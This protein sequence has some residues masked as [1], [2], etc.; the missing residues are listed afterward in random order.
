MIDPSKSTEFVDD[1]GDA[2]VTFDEPSHRMY[3]LREAVIL[4]EG[5]NMLK[6][7]G[8]DINDPNYK[9]RAKSKVAEAEADETK[10]IERNPAVRRFEFKAIVLKM[11]VGGQAITDPD[12]LVET[13]DN[14]TPD[15]GRWVD[16][17]VAEVWEKG[18]PTESEKN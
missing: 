14:L 17:C 2:L 1:S 11:V 6:A 3:G 4:K 12:K 13:Y 16:Q 10:K 8:I 5:G 15:A 7:L 9:E 18:E